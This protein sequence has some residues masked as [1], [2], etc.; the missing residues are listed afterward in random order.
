MPDIRVISDVAE[1]L[2]A[3]PVETGDSGDEV[4]AEGQAAIET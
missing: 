3:F 4:I 1:S 2:R